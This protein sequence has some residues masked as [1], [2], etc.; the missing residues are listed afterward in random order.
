MARASTFQK[1]FEHLDTLLCVCKRSG[2]FGGGTTVVMRDLRAY[3]T[4]YCVCV[5]ASRR[6]HSR[7]SSWRGHSWG[8][9]AEA[10]T[11]GE[12]QAEDAIGE[13][14]HLAI[15]SC[16]KH[17]ATNCNYFSRSQLEIWSVCMETSG[18][19]SSIVDWVFEQMP[20]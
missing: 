12:Q 16:T 2:K 3:Y 11:I 17:L 1:N 8:T 20:S 19:L 6:M 7:S 13:Q 4:L 15:F 5:L 10:D 9:A 14:Q 18:V